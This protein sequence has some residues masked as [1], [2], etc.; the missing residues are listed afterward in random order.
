MDDLIHQGKILYWGT[1]EWSAVELAEVYALCERYHLYPPQVEQPQYSMLY[2]ERVEQQ[3]LP[4]TQ[5]R[6]I[7][8]VTWS[9]LAEG[10][11]SGKYDN[12]IDEGSRFAHEQQGKDRF[13]NEKNVQRVRNLKQIADD[14]AITRSQLALAWIL[15]QEGVSSVITGAT[16]ATQVEDNVRAAD[17]S[18]S[19][20]ALRQI[21]V[22]LSQ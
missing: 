13:F 1:S 11:L 15:R 22:V 7:G 12:G 19:D 4:V 2:R 10:M 20:D 8:I 3:I 17:I 9:P 14:L 16:K 21:E 18:L 6:G 5:P